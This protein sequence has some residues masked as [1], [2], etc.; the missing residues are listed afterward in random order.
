MFSLYNTIISENNH[1]VFIKSKV[2]S[3]HLKFIIRII[4]CILNVT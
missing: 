3:I 2:I 4:N 1:S